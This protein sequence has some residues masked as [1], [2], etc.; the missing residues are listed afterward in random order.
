[1]NIFQLSNSALSQSQARSV[2]LAE[3]NILY[4]SSKQTRLSGS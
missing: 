4:T 2:T 1:M 3:T